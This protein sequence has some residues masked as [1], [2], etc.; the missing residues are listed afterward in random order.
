MEKFPIVDTHVHHVAP[1]TIEIP[2]AIRSSSP[3]QILSPQRLQ[4]RVW[5]T[6][7]RNPSSLSSA[8]HIPMTA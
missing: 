8:I 7:H 3:K 6:G 4:R 1:G 5:R 2:V